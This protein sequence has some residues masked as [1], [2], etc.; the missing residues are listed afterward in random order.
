M[1]DGDDLRVGHEPGVVVEAGD[2]RDGASV[3]TRYRPAG[4]YM[5]HG[6]AKSKLG[7]SPLRKDRVQLVDE[8]DPGVLVRDERLAVADDADLETVGERVQRVVE[9]GRAG[10]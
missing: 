2:L 10:Y 4:N 7:V 5:P 3:E 1:V 8:A 9:R 6:T